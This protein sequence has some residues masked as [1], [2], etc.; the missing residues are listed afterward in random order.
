[1]YKIILALFFLSLGVKAYFLDTYEASRDAFVQVSREYVQSNPGSIYNFINFESKL[2]G[3]TIDYLYIPHTNNPKGLVIVT[4]GVHGVEGFAGSAV[5]RMFV[6]EILS[7]TK[8]PN[9]GILFVHGVNPYGFKKKLRV[10][11]NNIDLNR[12]FA[13]DRSFFDIPNEGY[14]RLND[15]L[16]PQSPVDSGFLD[17]LFYYYSSA[18]ELIKYSKKDLRQSI[19][20]G[21]YKNE[22]GIF[23]GGKKPEPHVD[24][25][26]RIV[27]N[28]SERFEAIFHIDLHT[29]FGERGKLHL[30]G[31]SKI[32]ERAKDKLNLIFRGKKIDWGTDKDFYDVNGDFGQFIVKLFENKKW[33][34]PMTFEYGTLNSQ[35]LWGGLEVL[36][37][38]RAENQGR[39]YG[40][41]NSRSEINTKNSFLEMFYPS[42]TEW[43]EKILNQSREILP[44][45]LHRFSRL[46]TDI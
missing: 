25:F 11:E 37:R 43:R 15:F 23:F 18:K 14:E 7:K 10:T 2:D 46:G 26:Q 21:Q 39:L 32:P 40:Y 27:L 44:E 9:L 1:M 8:Y 20:Q 17:R 6:K 34:L 28:F 45:V 38:V 36:Y 31:S 35:T 30:F 12:N 13:L 5:Q 19:V 42:D 33:V 41:K 24:L 16:N 22:R 4:S 29:G 3:L